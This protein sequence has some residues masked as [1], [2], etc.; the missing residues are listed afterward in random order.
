MLAIALVEVVHFA[1]PG[2]LVAYGAAQAL[3]SAGLHCASMRIAIVGPAHPFKGGVAQHTTVLAKRLAAAGHDVEIV[4]WLRQ[5][6]QRLYPGGQALDT[7]EIEHFRPTRRLL[8][9]N[10][11]DTWIRVGRQL[12]DRDLVIIAYITPVQVPPYRTLIAAMRGGNAQVVVV[13]HNVLPHER[14]RF[15]KRAVSLLFNAADR[16]VAHTD[17]EAVIA[18]TLTN[19]PVVAVP[20]APAMPPGFERR[21]PMPGEHRRLIFFGIVRQC[22]DLDVLVRALA[23][24]PADVRLR[25]VGEF[26]GG[27]TEIER[28]CAELGIAGRVD[29]RDGYIPVDEVPAQFADV[30]ALVLPY[31][32]ATVG[33]GV[34]TAFEFGVPAIATRAGHLTDDIRDGINGFVVEPDDVGALADA[35]NRF[36]MPGVPEKMRAEVKPVDPD[37]YWSRYLHALLSAEGFSDRRKPQLAYSEIQ[38]KMLDEATR[39]TKARKIISV[40]HHF[41]GRPS[42]EGL[43]ALDIGCSAGF[44]AD[45]LAR[46]GAKTAGVDIDVPGLCRAEERFG[47]RVQFICASGD[48]LPMPADSVD[49]VVFNHIYEHVVDP[50]AILT[51]IHRVLKP[52]G[53]AYLGLANKHQIIEPHYQLPFL[54]WLPQRVANSYV[55]RFSDSDEY[56]ESFRTRKG[57]KQMLRGFHVWDYTI[58]IILRPD[59]FGSGD[60]VTRA[61]T[62]LPPLVVRMGMPIIPT[63]IWLATK[64]TGRPGPGGAPGLQHLD[65]SGATR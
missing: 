48:Q 23:K 9:W 45:E 13:S 34:W 40:L 51:E 43:S 44:I 16:I 49:V 21:V 58:P 10:R 7:P 18:R 33:Q 6:P 37:P 8:S 39:R 19:T 46:D 38:A 11:P 53:V 22:K 17:S 15:D 2:F 56:Y 1:R 26:W 41:L 28:L 24:T 47:D 12:R 62:R 31:R 20:M 61:M 32:T 30:D 14:S 50:D 35:L 27:T 54:S 52:N 55:R 59:L 63:F 25:V 36:Y 5:Y 4:T 42:L 3:G 65:L 64:G 60:Q 57:L 29:I